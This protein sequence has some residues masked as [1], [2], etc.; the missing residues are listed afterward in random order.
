MKKEYHTKTERN[1]KNV[2]LYCRVSTDEQ[3]DG[4]SLDMQE[5]YL[6][7]YCTDK[8]YNIIDIYKEDYSAK[9]YDMRRPEMARLYNYCKKH[10]KYYATIGYF[11]LAAANSLDCFN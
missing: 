11:I 4:C 10:K 5:L 3:A 8:E 7:R 6:R 1:M 2:I 9:H